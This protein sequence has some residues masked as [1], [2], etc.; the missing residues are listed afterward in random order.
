MKI[1]D[2][3]NKN[4]R[5]FENLDRGCVFKFADEYYMKTDAAIDPDLGLSCNAVNLLSGETVAF[6][7]NVDVVVIDC[8]LVIK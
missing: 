8:D 1:I 4:K 3:S 5:K 7:S 2:Y 6:T